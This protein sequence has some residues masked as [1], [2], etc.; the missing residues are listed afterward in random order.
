MSYL[1][2]PF[3]LFFLLLVSLLGLQLVLRKPLC[4]ESS[5]VY[6]IDKI[7]TAGTESIYSCSQFKSVSYSL[8][9]SDNLEGLQARLRAFEHLMTRLNLQGKF[10]IVIDEINKDQASELVNG[11]RIGSKLL[12]SGRLLEKFLLTKGLKNK[13][14]IV[15]PIFLE[16]VSD[17]FIND[18]DYRNLISEAWAKSFRELSLIEK[19]NVSKTI[20]GRL[21]GLRTAEEKTAIQFLEK[22]TLSTK[23]NMAFRNKLTELGYLDERE[24]A[25]TH[26]DFVIED[27]DGVFS[28]SELAMLAKEFRTVRSAIKTPQGLFLLPSLLKVQGIATD[29]LTAR[30]R[31]IFGSQAGIT[32]DTAAYFENTESLIMI[33]QGKLTEINFR[34]L[35]IGNATDFLSGNKGLEFI[36]IH[37]PSYKLVYKDLGSV[38]SYFDLVRSRDFSEKVHKILGW[39]R[40]EWLKDLA[41]Y[42]PIA[43]YDMI[44]FFRLN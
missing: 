31:L 23:M 11:V 22:L 32:S 30:H 34:P 24:L 33:G 40:T 36:Q 15:D 9:F 1:Y 19:L 6:K 26:F 37:L 41:A 2:R 8:Y 7:S 25:G 43:N 27:R 5:V 28:L 44:Q 17:F 21:S 39:S 13:T 42:K 35:F 10:V 20:Y 16:A 38:A 3:G 4:I 14:N 18:A 12:E 29:S